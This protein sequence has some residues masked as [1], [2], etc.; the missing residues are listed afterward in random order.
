MLLTLNGVVER[1]DSLGKNGE[2]KEVGKGKRKIAAAALIGAIAL[3][4]AALGKDKKTEAENTEPETMAEVATESMKQ[5]E[6]PVNENEAE[7][8]SALYRSMVRGSY[9]ET[10]NILNE[11]ESEFE[12]LL[13]ETFAGEQY[14][15]TEKE[16]DNGQVIR[17]LEPLSKSGRMEGMVVTRFN[18]VFYGSYLDGMPDG[19]CHAI[20]AMILDEP[21]Y[22]FADG[23]W[24]QGRMNGEGR[25]GYH[26][27]LDAPET[28]FVMTEK[29]GVYADNLLDGAFTYR[30]KNG[31]GEK[32]SWKMEAR[33]GVTLLND[34]WIHYPFRNEYM[35]GAEE[36]AARAYVLSEDKAEAVLWNNLILWDEKKAEK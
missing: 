33:Q 35:L 16:Y 26:Y 11:Y 25:T 17:M 10:A 34:N 23:I 28:G 12:R 31:E 27:Y 5:P 13:S 19:E 2:K 8:L 1:I 20:Q 22:T 15:Y 18:T 4:L 14:C 3:L 29:E 30:V 32:L 21:R 9:V 6:L 7:L 24:K 36:D